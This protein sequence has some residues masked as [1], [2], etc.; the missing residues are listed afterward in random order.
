MSDNQVHPGKDLNGA[1]RLGLLSHEDEIRLNKVIREGFH[2]MQEAVLA[3]ASDAAEI[4][5]LKDRVNLWGAKGVALDPNKKHINLIVDRVR[6]AAG[7]YPGHPDIIALGELVLVL[8]QQ[9]N[10]AH[11]W[12]TTANQG[13]VMFAAAKYLGR[14]LAYEDLAQEG[15]IG[16]MHAV[17]KYNHATGNRF[18][19]Y[20][21]WWIRQ[22]ITRA[23]MDKSRTIRQPVHVSQT[24]SKYFKTFH[25]LAASLRRK[26]S[27]EEVA[28]A[29]KMSEAVLSNVLNAPNEPVSISSPAWDDGV[30]LETLMTTR[31]TESVLQRID[32]EQRV[33]AVQRGLDFLT[34]R[35]AAIIR[36]RFGIGCNEHTLGEIAGKLRLSRERIR[37]IE[38]AAMFRLRHPKRKKALAGLMG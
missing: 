32:Y 1:D 29:L 12:M 16:L 28:K 17:F 37:Q 21:I 2:S 9:I 26:P 38:M 23:L 10:N 35:E 13:L 5:F 15:N 31:G 18:G 3:C 19:T 25:A 11:H 7:K 30:S 8:D 14:G 24:K 22:F 36:M 6:K 33:E 20:A 34:E 4:R 27:L